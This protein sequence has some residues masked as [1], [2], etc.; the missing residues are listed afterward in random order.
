MQFLPGHTAAIGAGERKTDMKD[1]REVYIHTGNVQGRG[2]AVQGQRR[3]PGRTGQ[4]GKPRNLYGMLLVCTWLVLI[5]QMAALFHLQS[6]MRKM[7]DILDRMAGQVRSVGWLSDR[8]EGQASLPEYHARGE[9]AGR[10]EIDYV[11]LCGLDE[12]PRPVKRD[13][14]EVLACLQQMAQGDETIADIYGNYTAY[15]DKMLEALANN[16]EMADFVKG[17]L[18]AGKQAEGGLTETERNQDFPLFLQWDPRWGYAE[19]GQEESNIGLS[20]CGP[21]CLSMVLYYL[22]GNEELTPDRIARYSMDN[23]YYVPGS[24]TAWAL[25]ED[26]PALYGLDVSQPRVSERTLRQAIDQGKMIICSM[27]PGDFTAAGHFIVIYGYDE[28]GFLVN[29]PNCVAR[30]RK[31]WDYQTIGKQM[32]NIWVIGNRVL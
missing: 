16:P 29:D 25:L 28:E 6:Q 18:T 11:N 32:K 9:G 1:N 19:Y 12:V 17:S 30:S 7:G 27:R 2:R 5:F 22:T 26:V 10:Q 21:T 13:R 15:S 20:G 3:Q 14:K 31:N 8:G 24:G 23:G 4:P